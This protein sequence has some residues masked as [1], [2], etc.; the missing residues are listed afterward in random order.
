MN[1]VMTDPWSMLRIG[2][3]AMNMLSYDMTEPSTWDRSAE[4]LVDRRSRPWDD[5]DRRPS[6]QD[7]RNFLC[8]GILANEFNAALDSKSLPR[9]I[10]DIMKKTAKTGG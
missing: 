9:E 1:S 8:H 3:S 4:E 7:R 2:I 10:I 6:H 5:A